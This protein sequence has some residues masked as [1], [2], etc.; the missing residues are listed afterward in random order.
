MKVSGAGGPQGTGG[1]LRS[2]KARRTGKAGAA[3]SIDR[4]EEAEAARQTGGAAPVAPVDAL[5]ALQEVPDA[6]QG[7]RQAIARAENMLDILDDVRV[8]LLEGRLPKARLMQLLRLVEQ[9][10]DSRTSFQDPRLQQ[11]LDEIE[12]RARV[13]LAKYEAHLGR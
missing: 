12:L 11:V 3:F 13:E 2:G 7:R 1:T 8:A 4:M 9:K 10:R 5:L 6:A